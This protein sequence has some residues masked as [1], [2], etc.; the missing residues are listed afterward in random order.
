MLSVHSQIV[1]GELVD[2]IDSEDYNFVV[3]LETEINS[4]HLM[5]CVGNIVTPWKIGLYHFYNLKIHYE[6]NNF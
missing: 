2:S 3:G 5:K 4:T 6:R 1:D